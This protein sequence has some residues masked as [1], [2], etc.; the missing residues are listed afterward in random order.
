MARDRFLTS[1]CLGGLTVCT[2]CFVAVILYQDVTR[3]PLL[4]T[5][6]S[7]SHDSLSDG[8]AHNPSHQEREGFQEA[9][10]PI[11]L[12]DLDKSR[13]A[14][15]QFDTRDITNGTYWHASSHWNSAYCKQHGHQYAYYALRP[16]AKC[17]SYNQTTELSPAWCKVKAML[18]AHDDFF[19]VDYFLYMDTDAVVSKQF[20]HLSLNDLMLNMTEKLN[21]TVS[22]KPVVFNQDSECW[23]CG[24][25]AQSKYFY[26]INSGTVAWFRSEKSAKVLERWW[27]SSLDPYEDTNPPLT[28]EFRTNWPWEQDRAMYLLHANDSIAHSIQVASQPE[29]PYTDIDQGHKDWCL[30]HLARSNCFVSHYC[31]DTASKENMMRLYNIYY[32]SAGINGSFHMLFL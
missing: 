1:R 3:L 8:R 28:F 26:C 13:F 17:L 12:A 23:W 9:T 24:L 32:A 10:T 5:V 7:T 21:W 20:A 31:E 30:S 15:V 2:L 16:N 11:P 27:Q 22:D 18:R 29:Q 14:I 6:K 19:S 4:K 25:V